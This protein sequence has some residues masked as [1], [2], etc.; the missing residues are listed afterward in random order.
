M[1]FKLIDKFFESVVA[2][3]LEQLIISE[4][5]VVFDPLPMN[6]EYY[7]NVNT[8]MFQKT[9]SYTRI[10]MRGNIVEYEPAREIIHLMASQILDKLK[11]DFVI[12]S[13]RINYMNK[14]C[15]EPTLKYD[16]PHVDIKKIDKNMYTI[17]YYLNDSDG[18]TILYNETC[19]GSLYS[20]EVPRDVSCLARIPPKKNRALIFNASQ[21]HSAPVY[22]F[23]DR[24]VI[25]LNITTEFPIL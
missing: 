14:S 11:V 7:K 10:L 3:R 15:A 18:D 19:R 24:Y 12:S 5:V 1:N 4:N 20:D 13:I 9:R 8:D 25:N 22:S 16:I 17:I 2:D 6:V 23:G 21:L